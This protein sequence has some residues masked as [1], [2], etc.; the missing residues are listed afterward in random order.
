MGSIK[1]Y[2]SDM[3]EE[4]RQRVQDDFMN[5]RVRIVVATLAF[6]MGLNKSDVRGVI[7]YNMPTSL[8][9]FVQEI[10]RAGRD[11]KPANCH[12][13]IDENKVRKY[14]IVCIMIIFSTIPCLP[15]SSRHVVHIIVILYGLFV[16]KIS[17]HTARVVKST[18]CL[19]V[20]IP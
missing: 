10:G 13:L 4:E 15:N 2:H 7:H 5:D 16:T 11:G 17:L 8:E 20:H 3:E 12:V 14:D 19:E 18:H 9:L 1:F 6:G